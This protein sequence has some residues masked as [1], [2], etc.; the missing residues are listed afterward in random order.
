MKIV[1]AKMHDT[2]KNLILTGVQYPIN[3]GY[4][5][6]VCLDAGYE[7]EMWDFCIEPFEPDYIIDKIKRAKPDILGVSC[8][9]S[10]IYN[11]H[12]LCSIAKNVDENILTIVGG[13][14]ITALPEECLEEFPS[15][16]MGVL[17]EAEGIIL[18]ICESVESG[19]LRPNNIPG[20]VFRDNGNIKFGPPHLSLPDVNEIPH[21]NRD[22]LQMERYAQKHSGRGISRNVWN[23]I[24]I[25]SA[26]GC[27]YACTFCNVELTH[28]RKMRERTPEHVMGEIEGCVAKFD[29]N[30]VLF[31]D[32]TF[33]IRKDRASEIV[34]SL[35]GA[36][37][38]AYS[39][40]AHVN[41]VDAEFLE[42]LAR[43]G[44]YRIMFGVESG[45]ERV[46][47]AIKKNSTRERIKEAVFAAKRASIPQVETTFILGSD[48][49]ETEED[50]L[51][52]EELIR[53]LQPDL[54]A[55]GIITPFPG[56]TQFTD[57][58]RM[59]FLDGLRWD[60]YQIFTETPPPWRIKNYSAEE[61]VKRRNSILKS[62]IW[63]P[64]YVLKQLAKIRS[65]G[66]LKY[67]AGMANSF[68]KVVIKHAN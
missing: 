57:L 62:Y 48:P 37:I 13:V 66:E 12:D 6:Q 43:T 8:V 20:T 54:L 39:V 65:F 16:D 59:G 23:V 9:T 14:H 21:P 26:R 24:E 58:K 2:G 44:C 35:P 15:F 4:L 68:Y 55:L 60:Q 64:R 41:T 33:T 47:R 10:A 1:F 28:G 32:S 52:T 53:E 63:T 45:S 27:P 42:T 49:W 38:K 5:A 3:I 56:T 29:T 17:Q 19:D 22:L 67:Y 25:D 18:D 31:N 11:G 46:L 50:M 7:V 30:F 36:G 51:A 61:L 40:N 34:R